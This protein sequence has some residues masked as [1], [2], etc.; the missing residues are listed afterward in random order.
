MSPPALS[1][2]TPRC[3][4]PGELPKPCW[5]RDGSRRQR[6]TWSSGA[7]S[8]WIMGTEYA[9]L[10]RLSLRSTVL[11][12]PAPFL[13]A[14]RWAVAGTAGEQRLAVRIPAN[15]GAVFHVPRVPELRRELRNNRNR[16]ET[17]RPNWSGKR[18]VHR[19][20]RAALDPPCL[21]SITRRPTAFLLSPSEPVSTNRKGVLN[22][23][24]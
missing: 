3:G 16:P 24:V 19:G 21:C 22:V 6:T 10:T 4:R 2:S 15:G 18:S 23:R 1:I 7:R 5:Q 11:T 20:H 9:K 17:R 13:T 12:L 8:F 14:H